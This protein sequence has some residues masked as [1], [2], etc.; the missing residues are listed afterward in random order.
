MEELNNQEWGW[1]VSGE[2]SV[3]PTFIQTLLNICSNIRTTATSNMS[4]EAYFDNLF[5]RLKKFHKNSFWG[6]KTQKN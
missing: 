3:G 6:T 2:I 1:P 4:L 5:Y